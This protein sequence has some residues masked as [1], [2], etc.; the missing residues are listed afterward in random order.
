MPRY[1]ATKN[2]MVR[3]DDQA[4]VQN[5]RTRFTLAQIN[6]GA[7]LLPAVP[8]FTYRL[9]DWTII[10]VGGAAAGATSL[11]LLGTR[12]GAVTLAA[13]AVAA[14]TRSAAVK[15]NSANVTLLADGAS[16]TPT[17]AN[18]AITV[19]KTGGAMTTATHFDVIASYALEAA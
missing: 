4:D 8:G 14:L 18:T 10:A 12:T 15:P 19:G 7:T 2:Q 11:D 9:I 16:H 1:D 5:I 3:D 13:I 6:A 17:D